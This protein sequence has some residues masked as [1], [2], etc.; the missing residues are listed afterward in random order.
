MTASESLPAVTV[1][2]IVS[3]EVALIFLFASRMVIVIVSPSLYEV[4]LSI[5]SEL[6]A[7]YPV[8]CAI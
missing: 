8:V 2:V 1:T 6:V 3:V 4:S 7:I 5:I